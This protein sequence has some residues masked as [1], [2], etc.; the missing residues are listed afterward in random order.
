[1]ATSIVLGYRNSSTYP[2]GKE[3]LLQ[4]GV[5]RVRMSTPPVLS[6]PAALPGVNAS[7]RA[8]GWVGEKKYRFE[9]SIVKPYEDQA[10]N[11]SA[12]L[13]Q[14]SHADRSTIVDRQVSC[15]SDRWSYPRG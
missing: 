10:Q 12:H 3:L 1:M 13:F 8:K 2:T 11:S 14:S 5:G 7:R 9:R 4:L 15:S 6:S